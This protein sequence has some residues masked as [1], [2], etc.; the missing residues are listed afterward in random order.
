LKPTGEEKVQ[1]KRSLLASENDD[2]SLI[3]GLDIGKLGDD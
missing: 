2:A 1:L 3:T